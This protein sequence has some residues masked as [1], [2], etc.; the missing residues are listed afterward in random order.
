MN[1]AR[2]RWG[3]ISKSALA[4]TIVGA[5]L[6][7]CGSAAA[8]S[9]SASSKSS[10]KTPYTFSI[11]ADE[12]G[13]NAPVGKLFVQGVEAYIDNVNAHG[14]INGHKIDVGTPFDSQSSEAGAATAYREA[15]SKQPLEIVNL[16]AYIAPGLSLLANGKTILVSSNAQLATELGRSLKPWFFDGQGGLPYVLEAYLEGLPK[17]LGGSLVGKKIDA[18]TFNA[19]SEEALASLVLDGVKKAGGKA[20]TDQVVDLTQ[21]SFASEAAQIAAS[22][23]TAVAMVLVGTQPGAFMSALKTAGYNG[24]VLNFVPGA[25]PSI[26]DAIRDPNYYAYR[27]STLPSASNPANVAA[28]KAGLD[29][30]GQ[31]DLGTGWLSAA[32]AVDGLKGC[33]SVCNASAVEHRLLSTPVNVAGA[34]GPITYTST[35]HSGVW[36]NGIYH[37]DAS[38]HAPA[39]VGQPFEV[40]GALAESLMSAKS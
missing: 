25:S 1:N 10:S 33:A 23:P 32:I 22:H 24:P 7:A 40:N 20:G 39:V 3:T 30:N 11:V 2:I 17:L 19:P 27:S 4:A 26:F 35:N 15:L 9:K 18:V 14:G 13:G 29:T 34:L 16:S 38:T 28:K 8:T 6:V 5:V 21:V 37:Y 12:T 31:S 36:P